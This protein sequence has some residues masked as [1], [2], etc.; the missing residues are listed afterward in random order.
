MMPGRGEAQ[1]VLTSQGRWDSTDRAPEVGA[2]T[3]HTQERWAAVGIQLLA[4]TSTLWFCPLS[5]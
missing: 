1:A 3:P 5:V 4:L 2:W